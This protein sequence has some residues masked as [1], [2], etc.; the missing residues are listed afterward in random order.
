MQQ[1]TQ[2]HEELLYWHYSIVGYNKQYESSIRSVKSRLQSSINSIVSSIKSSISS[3]ISSIKSSITHGG[4]MLLSERFS[5]ELQRHSF[6]AAPPPLN[7]HIYTQSGGRGHTTTEN[8]T[9][10][11]AMTS[12]TVNS[13]LYLK[14]KQHYY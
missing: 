12:T 2:Q 3:I 4:S 14:I 10:F 13:Q 6:R 7:T 5:V 8:I 9:L 1:F 11:T